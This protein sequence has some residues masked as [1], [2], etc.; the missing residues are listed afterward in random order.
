MVSGRVDSQYTLRLTSLPPASRRTSRARYVV[1]RPLT[2]DGTVSAVPRAPSPRTVSPA[3]V[4]S[5]L[6]VPSVSKSVTRA[7][8]P[9]ADACRLFTTTTDRLSYEYWMCNGSLAF[10]AP[11]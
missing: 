2:E 5:Y 11:K 3:A 6:C 8:S 9:D 4:L 10:F 7:V 1:E